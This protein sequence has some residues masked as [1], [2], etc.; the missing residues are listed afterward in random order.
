MKKPKPPIR[1]YLVKDE[2]ELEK[3]KEMYPQS[4]FIRCLKWVEL[5]LPEGACLVINDKGYKRFRL[6]TK[7]KSLND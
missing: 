4:D 6:E 2:K 3:I 1:T 7:G 5:R